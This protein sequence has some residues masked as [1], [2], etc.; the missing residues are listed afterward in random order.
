[1]YIALMGKSCQEHC[2]RAMKGE[3]RRSRPSHHHH[4]HQP[5]IYQSFDPCQPY[6]PSSPL[7]GESYPIQPHF[8]QPYPHQPGHPKQSLPFSPYRRN[9]ADVLPVPV[10]PNQS[11][12]PYSLPPVMYYPWARPENA[13]HSPHPNSLSN[14]Y[15]L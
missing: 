8:Y 9:S 11:W 3:E 15:G 10:N 5:H 7:R 2:D 4:Q 14:G 6:H 1:M 13:R 12:C